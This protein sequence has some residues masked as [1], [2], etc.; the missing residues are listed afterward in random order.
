MNIISYLC[1]YIFTC[2]NFIKFSRLIKH[3]YRLFNSHLY[4]TLP[5]S[6]PTISLN[7]SGCLSQANQNSQC[8]ICI[9]NS[10]INSET[11]LI[12]TSFPLPLSTT[13]L[14]SCR[15]QIIAKFPLVLMEML[16]NAIKVLQVKCGAF[17]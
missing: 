17:R 9:A 5:S 15:N 2:F 3:T 14:G 13:P 6:L 16:R 4:P 10:S 12:S 7:Q 11:E 1:R 8:N